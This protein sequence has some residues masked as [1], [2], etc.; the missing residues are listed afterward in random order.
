MDFEQTW[1]ILNP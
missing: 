1:Y